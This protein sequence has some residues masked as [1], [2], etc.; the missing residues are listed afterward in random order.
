MSVDACIALC[1]DRGSIPL[2]S[3]MRNQPVILKVKS[4]DIA[5][6]FIFMNQIY[7][8]QNLV[9]LNK[10]TL[11]VGRSPSYLLCGGFFEQ[12]NK[13]GTPVPDLNL[14]SMCSS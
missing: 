6:F 4:L 11:L 8:S 14:S 9:N 13:P 10:I 5:G 12:K 1:L 7:L 3:I 2:T